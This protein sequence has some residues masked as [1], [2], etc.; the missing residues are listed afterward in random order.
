MV[1]D[2]SGAGCWRFRRRT[3]PALGVDTVGGVWHHSYIR[4]IVWAYRAP[5]EVQSTAARS[6]AGQLAGPRAESAPLTRAVRA[7]AW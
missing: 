1:A 4:S 3:L 5:P 2:L 7:G 6:I